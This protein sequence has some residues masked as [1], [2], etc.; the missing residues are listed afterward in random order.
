MKITQLPDDGERR[1]LQVE[2]DWG[3]LAADYEDVVSAYSRV[4]IPGFRPGRVPRSVVEQRLQ[5][6]IIDDLSQ[7]AAHR[8]GREALRESG[9]ESLGPVEV[10]AIECAK[11]KAFRF[12]ARFWPMPVF[13]LPD[14]NSLVIEKD[15][16]DPRDQI[17][18]MLL[19]MVTFDVPGDAVLAEMDEDDEKDSEAWK[20]A[21]DRVR[22]MLIL[23]KIAVREGIE[24]SEADVEQRIK[25]KALEFGTSPDALRAELE[26]GGGT[27]RLRDMLLAESTLEYLVERAT[28]RKGAP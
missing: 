24:V 14:L 10:G 18:H 2:A 22:L 6:E 8:L 23:K 9:S 3:V 13:G 20:S 12:V 21:A 17:S 4:E 28:E 27:Q 16:S 15:G 25:E 19:E 11:G 1:V 26:E 5:K 7:R